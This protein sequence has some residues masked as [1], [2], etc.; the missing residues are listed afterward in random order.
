MLCVVHQSRF[1]IHMQKWILLWFGTGFKD[2][3]LWKVWYHVQL[4]SLPNISLSN[5]EY[6]HTHTHIYIYTHTVSI[7]IYIS[8]RTPIQCRDP[9]IQYT[10]PGFLGI[11]ALVVNFQT[12][13]LGINVKFWVPTPRICCYSA[14]TAKHRRTGNNSLTYS[15]DCLKGK[16]TGNHSISPVFPTIKYKG[17]LENAPLTNR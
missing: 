17:A 9:V 1:D 11:N 12:H 3:I 15:L 7:Y 5:I 16:P 10:K 4:A 6:H 13:Q 2:S 14:Y 8:Y